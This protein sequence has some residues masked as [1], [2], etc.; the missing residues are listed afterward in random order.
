MPSDMKVNFIRQPIRCTKKEVDSLNSRI[1][2]EPNSSRKT[3]LRSRFGDKGG[4]ERKRD[5]LKPIIP[6]TLHNVMEAGCGCVGNS[7]FADGLMRSEAYHSTC[8]IHKPRSTG[9]DAHGYGA[10]RGRIIDYADAR[11]RTGHVGV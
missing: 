3:D 7:H 5:N 8:A 4:K 2:I 11:D 6:S 9:M 1:W 10:K